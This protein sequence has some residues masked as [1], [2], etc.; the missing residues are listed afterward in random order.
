MKKA[1]IV[2]CWMMF[3]LPGFGNFD[4][5]AVG[6]AEDFTKLSLEELMEVEL[7][8][9]AK[10]SQKLSQTAAAAFVISDEDIRRSGVTSIPEALRMV[11]GL[12][13]ARINSTQWAVSARGFN[14]R[15]SN[16]LLVLMD[17]RS[18]YSPLF[19][20]VFWDTQDTFIEDI[21]RIEVIRGP[22]A[23]LWGANAVNGIINIITKHAKDTQGTAVSAGM[24][25]EEIF[26]GVRYGGKVDKGNYRIYA[27]YVNRD[28]S[29]DAQGKGTSDTLDMYRSGF[30][31]DK[32]IGI[33]GDKIT[34]QGDVYTGSS[35]Q[36]VPVPSANMAD[37][38][39]V[40]QTFVRNQKADISLNGFNLMGRW[41]HSFSKN[42]SSML[43]IYADY[44]RRD[45]AAGEIIQNN[46][47]AD[48]QHKIT[49]GSRTEI[50]WG[51]GYRVYQ[52][53]LP[54]NYWLCFEPD[55]QTD[56]LYSGFFQVEQVL[57]PDTVRATLGAK[58]EHNDYTGF[59]FQ[60]NLRL[61]WTPAKEHSLWASVSRAVRTPSRYQYDVR[62]WA[63]SMPTDPRLAAAAPLPITAMYY[64]GN[65]ETESEDVIAA[66]LGYRVQPTERFSADLALF[67]NFYKNLSSSAR[68]MPYPDPPL[69]K[70]NLHSGNSLSADTYG[71]EL[72]VVWQVFHPLKL[73]A[74]YTLFGSDFEKGTLFR[75]ALANEDDDP[76]HQVSVRASLNL[77]QNIETDLWFRYT[78][79]I[80]SGTVKSYSSVDVRLGWNPRKNI[81]ISIGG[82][83][84]LDSGHPEFVNSFYKSIDSEIEREFYGKVLWRF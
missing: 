74:A 17:G 4:A 6:E 43:Q 2:M 8:S 14:S 64:Y 12:D 44:D 16:K 57:I 82:R 1:K 39:P 75:N 66:E 53:E 46:F 5:M 65:Q 40:S 59:E 76:R 54:C 38:D 83:N 31:M 33:S 84:L 45:E 30:R 22:G 27:K 13:V 79:D 52:D 11:P 48:F 15:F 47:D 69:W 36:I 70:V 23:S 77:P 50:I 42:S 24:G 41:E 21:E 68:D 49:A 73:A 3:F 71:A 35:D 19:S 56:H 81:E 9:A 60:P 28:E 34:L 78:D 7:T 80:L 32:E 20:G 62:F 61:L 37:Y 58:I 10:K 51:L 29:E 26:G 72:S 67:Y 63:A 25:T 18:V 55:S